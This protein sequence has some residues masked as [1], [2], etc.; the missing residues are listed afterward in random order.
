GASG[1]H[2]TGGALNTVQGNYVGTDAAG[3]SPLGNGQGIA[4]DG[5]A[6]DNTIGGAIPGAGNL[7]SGNSTNGIS[8][9][10]AGT[11]NRILGNAIGTDA[12]ETTTANLGNDVGIDVQSTDGTIIGSTSPGAG[13]VIGGSSDAG[14]IVLGNSTSTRISGNYIGTDRS[15]SLDLGNPTGI[16]IV[17]GANNNNQVGPNNVIAHSADFGIEM[18]NGV[19]NRFSANSIHD[20][21]NEG[22]HL[23]G[24]NNDQAAPAL[25]SAARGGSTTQIAGTLHSAAATSYFI[26]YFLTPT[27]TGQPQGQFYLGF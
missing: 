21:G 13:N 9:I 27:C 7:V 16:R 19:G 6:H 20:N 8:V 12:G 17:N 25:T 26:E 5:A 14:I 15:D 3:T 4:V 11:G 1:I 22:I 10:S 24:G 2:V 18:D 23:G